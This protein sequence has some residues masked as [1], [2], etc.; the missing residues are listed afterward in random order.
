MAA[1]RERSCGLYADGHPRLEDCVSLDNP[2]RNGI[3]D[4]AIQWMRKSTDEFARRLRG[5]LRVL[6]QGDDVANLA[7]N[8][9]IPGLDRE[10]VRLVP[11]QIV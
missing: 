7:Q 5:Q 2:I 1:R 4:R 11:E 3:D 10:T 9:Q 8:G 6:I